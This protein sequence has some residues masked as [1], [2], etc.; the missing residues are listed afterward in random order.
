MKKVI[1]ITGASSGMGKNF[2]LDLLK[3]G[4][5]VYGL[6]RRV[7]KM[8][9]IVKAGG[10]AIAMDITQETQVENAVNQILHEQGKVDVLINNAGYA[11]YGPVEES[12][13]DSARR[14]F[15]VNMFGLASITQKVIPIMRKYKSGRVIN[16]SSMGGKMYTPF[17]AWYHATKH[18]LEGWSDCLRLELESFGIDVVIIEPGGIETEFTNV[19]LEN[20]Q[21]DANNGPYAD[22]LQKIIKSTGEMAEKGQLSSPSVITN[23]IDKAVHSKRPKTRYVAGSFAKPLMFMRK[24]LGDRRFDKILMRQLQ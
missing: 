17:G 19:F 5:I 4:H 2:A 10:K 6:A 9:D 3:K 7:E 23:L 15:E 12:T 11:L 16:I 20:L 21:G 18:A 24:Y 22:S 13:I 8:D 1:V 14:Q